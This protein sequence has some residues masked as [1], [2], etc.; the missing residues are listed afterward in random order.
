MAAVR[1]PDDAPWMSYFSPTRYRINAPVMSEKVRGTIDMHE[2]PSSFHGNTIG[3][4]S[5]AHSESSMIGRIDRP[6]I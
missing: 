1:M 6:A 3:I 5:E 2:C 4:S